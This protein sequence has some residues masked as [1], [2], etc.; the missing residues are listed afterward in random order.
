[1]T[2]SYGTEKKEDREDNVVNGNA[3]VD[4][5]NSEQYLRMHYCWIGRKGGG[6]STAGL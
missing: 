6:N 1:V 2:F 5:A 3:L 4:T